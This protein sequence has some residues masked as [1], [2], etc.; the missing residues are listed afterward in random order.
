MEDL[1]NQRRRRQ[2]NRGAGREAR[3]RRP[4]MQPLAGPAAQAGP[5]ADS[6]AGCTRCRGLQESAPRSAARLPSLL[7]HPHAQAAQPAERLPAAAHAAR[8]LSRRPPAPAA[9]RPGPAGFLRHVHA[10]AGGRSGP[11]DK[12]QAGEGCGGGGLGRLRR[13]GSNQ[14]RQLP[15]KPAFGTRARS[16]VVVR[17]G[18][19]GTHVARAILTGRG[20]AATWHN[21]LARLWVSAEHAP[22]PSRSLIDSAKNQEGLRRNWKRY[23]RVRF[24]TFFF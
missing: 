23:A 8:G 14:R 12:V 3:P 19:L 7:A 2:R 16:G 13:T 24:Q 1:C 4:W 22:S 15:E 6:A 10:P 20:P 5:R 21:L 11:R 9:R 17:G 18:S